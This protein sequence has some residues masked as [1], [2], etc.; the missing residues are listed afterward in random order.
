MAATATRAAPSVVYDLFRAFSVSENTSRLLFGRLP[1]GNHLPED[2]ATPLALQHP[3]VSLLHQTSFWRVGY[4]M[5]RLQ[6]SVLHAVN[7]AVGRT[8]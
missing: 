8:A 6:T 7:G 1:R 5:V 4:A 3:D 2:F